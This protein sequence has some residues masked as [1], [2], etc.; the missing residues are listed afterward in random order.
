[1]ARHKPSGATD[2]KKA[3]K[4]HLTEGMTEKTLTD[5]TVLLLKPGR[6]YSFGGNLLKPGS[7]YSFGGN[8]LKPGSPY[9][10]GGNL[11]KPGRAYCSPVPC[12][13]SRAYKWN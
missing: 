6:A 9:S 12:R 5:L 1:M 7:P 10:F 8:L 11:L 4:R 3:K 2:R 13:L